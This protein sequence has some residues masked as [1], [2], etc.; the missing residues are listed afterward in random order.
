MATERRRKQNREA[1][2]RF[3]YKNR[4]KILAKHKKRVVKTVVC[5]YCLAGPMRSDSL[6]R[7]L[8]VCRL[9]NYEL[10]PRKK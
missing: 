10:V 2:M 8:K 5:E 4:E 9:V 7:H 1:A 6:R 3:Y